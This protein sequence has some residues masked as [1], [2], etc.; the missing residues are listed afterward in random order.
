LHHATKPRAILQ[1]GAPLAPVERRNA[2]IA[3]HCNT[4]WLDQFPSDAWSS[5]S[6]Q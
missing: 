6:G 1:Q 5:S 4:I 2:A 3:T